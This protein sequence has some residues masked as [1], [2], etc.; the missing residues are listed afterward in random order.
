MPRVRL[1]DVARAAGVSKSTASRALNDPL[2]PLREETRA[3]VR[4]AVEELAY[5]P[6]AGARALKR[7]DTGALGLVVPDLTNPVW[8]RIVRG[9]VNQA[10]DRDFS[11]LLIEDVEP[12][13]TQAMVDDLV[14]AGRIDALVMASATPGHPLVAALPDLLVAHVFLNRAVAGS[15]RN[16]VARDAATSELALDHLHGL[17]HRAVGLVSGPPGLSTIE[18]RAASFAAR[19]ALLGLDAAP[20]VP[21]ELS[22]QGGA[23]AM[24][25]LLDGGP[26]VTAV[27]VNLLSQAI[28]VLSAL[29]EAGLEV[30]GDVS[31]VCYDDLPLADYLRPALTRSACRWRSSAPWA[32]TRRSRRCWA[33]PRA[34]CCS[35]SSR[36]SSSP[37]ARHRRGPGGDPLTA[38]APSASLARG[39]CW[40]RPRA[41]ARHKAPYANVRS[42]CCHACAA[43]GVR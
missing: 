33:G 41:S 16:V 19:A 2:A 24:R 5:R 7:A 23:E 31:I 43:Q 4:K 21:A 26:P 9:A 17:G 20:I 15:G 39:G 30:P 10:R 1:E 38:A 3:R 11:V 40:K 6:H 22:E 35:A 14:R 13:A 8:A 18:A 25:A 27:A 42:T 12:A 34:T 37:A 29:W 32:S 36:S 28:G